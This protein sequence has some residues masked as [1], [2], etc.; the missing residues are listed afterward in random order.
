MVLHFGWQQLADFL[1]HTEIFSD[2]EFLFFP[3]D[4]GAFDSRGQEIARSVATLLTRLGVSFGILG[5]REVSDGNEA[6]AMGESELFHLL[7]E[8]NIEHFNKL[9]V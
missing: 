5:D 4:V 6:N 2:Q 3:G 8:E 7:A 9:N 1:F